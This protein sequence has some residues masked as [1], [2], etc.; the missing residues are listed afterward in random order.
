[1]SNLLLEELVNVQSDYLSLL[2]ELDKIPQ[3]KISLDII[4]SVN[5]FWYEKRNI[6]KLMCEYLFMGKDTYCF[7]AATIY[8]VDDKDQ[9]SF[10]LLGEYHVFDDPIPSY[11]NTLTLDSDKVYLKKMKTIISNTIKDNIRIIEELK[12]D[13][14]IL[15]LRYLSGVLNQ[16]QEK[17]DE[18]AE[19]LFCNFFTNITS[20][21]EYKTKIVTAGDLVEH[22]NRDNSAFILLFDKDNPSEKWADRIQKFKEKNNHF[23]SKTLSNGEIFLI[24]VFSHLRQALALLDIEE[25]F[26]VIPFIRSFIPLHYYSLLSSAV[27]NN[28]KRESALNYVESKQWKTQISFFLYR[29][30]RKKEISYTLQELKQK[31]IEIDFENRIF[32]DIECSVDEKEIST[33][34]H[35]VNKLLDEIE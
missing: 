18:M 8:D 32:A 15:P 35:V 7:S 9:N 11:L 27:E 12:G 21:K 1:M 13:L 25:T 29:E 3:D 17:H 20:I 19:K 30:F 28:L 5:V 34:I 23:D 22:L 10:F 26:G 2:K 6:V 14:I 24:A 16:H 4:D 31:A 33:I